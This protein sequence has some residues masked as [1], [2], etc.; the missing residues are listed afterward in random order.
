MGSL[1]LVN[2]HSLLFRLNKQFNL[3]VGSCGCADNNLHIICG[4][5]ICGMLYNNWQFS[6]CISM[7]VGVHVIVL[8]LVVSVGCVFEPFIL[9]KDAKPLGLLACLPFFFL[10]VFMDLNLK[11]GAFANTMFYYNN[12]CTI[13]VL[14]MSG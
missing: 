12:L 2:I 11:G 4:K 5:R 10:I 8:L 3:C 7:C 1:C 6:V 9:F 13:I 14:I